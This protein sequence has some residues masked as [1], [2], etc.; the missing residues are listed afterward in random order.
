MGTIQ[1]K[2]R[3]FWRRVERVS[4]GCWLWTGAKHERGYGRVRWDGRVLAAHRVAWLLSHDDELPPDELCVLHTCDEPSCVNPEH[5]F[6][7]THR[8]NAQQRASKGRTVGRLPRTMEEAERWLRDAHDSRA[9]ID[10][11]IQSLEGWI[12]E[13]QG[14]EDMMGIV[15][16]SAK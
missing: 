12:E 4:W 7:G 3:K 13:Q 2:Q 14:I 11:R 8:E 16:K 6:L 9:R 15:W 1:A 10:R 5:L